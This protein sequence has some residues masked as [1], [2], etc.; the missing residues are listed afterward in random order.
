MQIFLTAATITKKTLF[1]RPVNDR[2]SWYKA[3]KYKGKQQ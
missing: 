3:L 1:D 2:A